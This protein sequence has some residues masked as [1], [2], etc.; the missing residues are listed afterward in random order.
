V[1]KKNES[2]G[3]LKEN[4]YFFFAAFFSFFFA[5]LATVLTSKATIDFNLYLKFAKALAYRLN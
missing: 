1:K 4:A 2:L 3:K 5:T